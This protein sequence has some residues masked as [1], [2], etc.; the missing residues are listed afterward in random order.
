[1][2]S[3][4]IRMQKPA[5]LREFMCI[6]FTSRCCCATTRQQ[7]FSR[8]REPVCVRRLLCVSA[9]C[10]EQLGRCGLSQIT[11]HSIILSDVANESA[12]VNRSNDLDGEFQHPS[13]RSCINV[14][15][16]IS[17]AMNHVSCKST[18]EHVMNKQKLIQ[19]YSGGC[20]TNDVWFN[21]CARYCFAV[22]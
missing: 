5:S 3:C 16:P 12:A 21:I 14:C 6:S 17:L 13:P 8:R 2:C 7:R 22:C 19:L 9:G 18:Q 15:R 10:N 4:G 1:M 20:S 11:P